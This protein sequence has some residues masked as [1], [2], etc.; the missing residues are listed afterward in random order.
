MVLRL[1]LRELSAIVLLR[2][3]VVVEVQWQ[4]ARLFDHFVTRLV[5]VV[6]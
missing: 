2:L 4:L 6:L 1:C 5:A 3:V